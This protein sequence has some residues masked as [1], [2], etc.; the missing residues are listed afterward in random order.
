MLGLDRGAARAGWTVLLMLT[1]TALIY[2]IRN[3]LLLFTVAL[4]VAY[5]L[6]PLV[7][8]VDR[9]AARRIPRTLS[10]AVVYVLLLGLVITGAG[11]MV[12]RIVN[13]AGTL[14]VRLP[15]YLKSFDAPREL[16]LPASLKPIEAQARA[17]VRA[18]IEASAKEIVPLMQRAGM[19]V[20][21]ALGN[22]GYV[23]LVPILSFFF[24]KDARAFRQT[25]VGHFINSDRRT[26]VE[27]I[28]SDVNLLLA[29]YM[30]AVVLLAAATLVSYGI[31][32]EVTGVPYALLLAGVAGVLE[33]IPVLGPLTAS[34][35]ILLVAGFTGYQ[36]LLWIL[37]FLGAYRIFQDYVLQPYLMSAGVAL[38][39]MLVI[40]GVLAGEQLGGVAGMFLSIPVLATLRVVYVRLL[41]VHR[42][43]RSEVQ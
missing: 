38:H 17:A 33:V 41:K 26:L 19:K 42:A 39:P 22:L 3:T 13:E 18:Q 16:P 36:H 12:N 6:A 8:L 43:C 11:F 31:F 21:A 27:D 9:L 35:I 32:L 37:I 30:R 23:I 4:L 24:L 5:L 34:A 2:L 15:E 7:D 29:Q 25:L 40:F 10:L 1:A 20:L 14:A 28:T